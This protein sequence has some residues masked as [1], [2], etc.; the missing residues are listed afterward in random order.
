MMLHGR[1][2]SHLSSGRRRADTGEG[3]GNRINVP[4]RRRNKE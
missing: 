1:G 4:I 2:S 3:D